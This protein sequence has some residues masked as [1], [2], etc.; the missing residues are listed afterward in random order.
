MMDGKP[1]IPF[2]LFLFR[3]IFIKRNIALVSSCCLIVIILV[4]SFYIDIVFKSC[5]SVDVDSHIVV[6]SKPIN[7][8]FY[9]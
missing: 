2:Q 3:S 6:P 9:C 5:I 7:L 4:L 1:I 8:R